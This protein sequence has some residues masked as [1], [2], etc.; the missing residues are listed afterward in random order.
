[1]KHRNLFFSILYV[2]A[3]SLVSSTTFAAVLT[4]ED[5]PHEQELQGAGD[6]VISEGYTLIYTPAPEEPYPVGFTSVGSIWRFNGR[7]TAL[8]ANSCSADTKLTSNDNEPLTLTSIDLDELNGDDSGTVT[9]TGITVDDTYV[10]KTVRLNGKASWQRF[11]FSS[12]FSNLKSVSW[13]QG[14]CI[15]NPPHMFDNIHVMPTKK[16]RG[17]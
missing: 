16:N 9:F 3:L 12:A 13:T 1:M 11:H 4:F 6:T 2:T 15:I 5:L 17:N 14:D 10:Q 7:S 8:L